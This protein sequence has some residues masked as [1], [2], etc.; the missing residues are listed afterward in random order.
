MHLNFKE[1]AGA[2][3]NKFKHT[4]AQ[5][6]LADKRFDICL[7]CPSKK[8][9][10]KNKEWALVCGECGCPL[11]AKIYTNNTYLDDTGSCPLGKWKEIEIEYLKNNP[12]KFDTPTKTDKTLL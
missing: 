4:P 3:Y 8:E 5:K 11:K 7:E 12:T 10:I 6:D 9:G 1:I 2:W